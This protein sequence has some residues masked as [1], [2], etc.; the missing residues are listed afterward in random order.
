MTEHEDLRDWDAAYLLGSL[1]ADDRR[2]YERHL[3]DCDACAS[4]VAELAGLPGLLAK[5]P[6]P[7]AE[8]LLERTP[9]PAPDLL[10]ALVHHV[11]RRRRRVRRWALGLTV[12]AVATGL[13]VA[14][15]V[16]PGLLVPSTPGPAPAS[17]A[18]ELQAVTPSPLAA[19][20]RLVEEKWGTH[21]EME[22]TYAAGNRY[23]PAAEYAMYVTDD[24]GDSMEVATWTAGPGQTA[25]P[26]GTTAVALAQI[27][28]VEVRS[29]PDGAVLLRG[30][31]G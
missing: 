14:A 3:A 13:A 23:S 8:E 15:M 1:S 22:C 21:I 27:R 26:S 19:S 4:L 25:T 30:S 2:R 24:S 29:V 28:F 17:A 12:G 18:V 11:A 9:P 10:P 7:E 6:A 31:P 16:G 20:I 5:V